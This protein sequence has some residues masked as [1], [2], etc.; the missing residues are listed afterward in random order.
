MNNNINLIAFGTF[1]NPNGFRQTFFSGNEELAKVVK[2]FDLN[3]NAIKLVPNSKIYALRKERLNGL[4]GISYTI[5]SFAKEQNSDR[6]GTFIGSSILYTTEIG[7]ESLT[8][9]L[10]NEFHENLIAKNVQNDVIKVNHSDNFSVLSPRDFDKISYNL[11][12]IEDV[13]FNQFSN[14]SLVVYSE[15][16]FEKIKTL[17][18]KSLVLLNLY[19]TI[20]FTDNNEIAEFVY[21][22]GLFTFVKIDGFD[23]EIENIKTEKK[24]KILNSISEFE[25]ENENLLKDKETVI[26]ELKSQNVKNLQIHE[27][28][29]KIL[30]ETKLNIEKI[31]TFYIEFSTL[32]DDFANQLKAGRKPET[33]RELYKENKAIFINSVAYL[34]QPQYSKKIQKPKTNSNLQ[35]EKINIQETTYQQYS[36][37]DGESIKH[38]HKK[39]RNNTKLI[40]SLLV[41]IFIIILIV[42]L[43]GLYQSCENDNSARNTQTTEQPTSSLDQKKQEQVASKPE[44]AKQEQPKLNPI[45]NDELSRKDVKQIMKEGIKGKTVT[46]IVEIIFKKNPTDIASIYSNQKA[47]YEQEL[48]SENAG[49]FKNYICSSDSIGKIPTYKKQ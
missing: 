9:R 16:K 21:H 48:V 24:Q 15:I 31:N 8:L 46:Q 18:S 32:L 17:F 19:D 33:V 13:I 26:D 41:T 39:R 43:F 6:G 29:Q 40:S 38:H 12:N 20:Y 36:L 23:Q 27:E 49:F 11:K 44:S 10:L 5:Y 47:L 22:K 34:K 14:K 2:T 3:S 28:N 7:D 35:V 45:P 30:N 4:N 1:G 42:L 37:S 25:R